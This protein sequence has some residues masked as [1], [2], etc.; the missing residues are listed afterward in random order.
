MG[1]DAIVLL[2]RRG[3]RVV[4]R[5]MSMMVMVVVVMSPIEGRQR[6]LDSPGPHHP[7]LDRGSYPRDEELFDFRHVLQLGS[8]S[9]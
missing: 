1:S 3:R 4:C 8:R 5:G 6:D 7:V 2:I 9:E